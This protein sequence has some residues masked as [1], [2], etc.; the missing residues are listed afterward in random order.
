VTSGFVL[1]AL[2]AT[3]AA[4]GRRDVDLLLTADTEGRVHAC[5]SCSTAGGLGDLAR[6]AAAVGQLRNSRVSSLLIDAGNFLIGPDSLDSGGRVIVA[7]YGRLG[8]DA[9]NLSYRDFRLGKAATLALL[10]GA[11][12]KAISANLI[13]EAT[14]RTVVEPFLVKRTGRSRVALLGV[15]E[16]PPGVG[17]LQHVAEQLAGL[18]VRPPADALAEWLP[19]ARAV[20]DVTVLAF[21]GSAEG[22][23][24]VTS[25]FR[26][27][28]AAILV[29]GLR[30]ADL[31][32]RA[33]P[34]VVAVDEGGTQIAAV[35]L[36]A[37]GRAEVRQ[38]PV[39]GRFQQDPGMLDLLRTFGVRALEGGKTPPVK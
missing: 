9:V 13:D 26:G 7:A 39:D 37:S 20:S 1:L 32:D 35:L 2:V 38:V 22:L 15:T 5:A 12:F 36:P 6:R 21:D 17:R 31:P 33:D 4:C 8:Y 28:L 19:K 23:A 10:R 29:A 34:L 24:A 27:Q 16:L 14:G 25:K 3:A 18:R 11:A 30:P